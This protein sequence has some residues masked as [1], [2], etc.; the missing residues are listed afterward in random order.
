MLYS[1]SGNIKNGV[2][3][4]TLLLA[5]IILC[6]GCSFPSEEE[7]KTNGSIESTKTDSL[8]YFDIESEQNTVLAQYEIELYWDEDIIGMMQHGTV[9]TCEI[10]TTT[11]RHT[12]KA[13]SASDNDIEGTVQVTISG[14][15]TVHCV[16]HSRTKRIDIK[17]INVIEGLPQKPIMPIVTGMT[18]GEAR[19]LLIEL[20]FVNIEYTTKDNSSIWNEDNW[21]IIEQNIESGTVIDRTEKIVLTCKKI[22]EPPTTSE[23]VAELGGVVAF[24]GE[25]K[26]SNGKT[27][28]IVDCN[29]NTL[30]R[31]GQNGNEVKEYVINGSIDGTF[32]AGD[33]KYYIYKNNSSIS[34]VH[35]EY[36]GHARTNKSANLNLTS[37]DYAYSIMAQCH[38]NAQKEKENDPYSE[39]F[40]G[41]IICFGQYEQDNEVKPIEW[42]VLRSNDERTLLVSKYV[43]SLQTYTGNKDTSAECTWSSSTIRK[44]LNGDFYNEAFSGAEKN[45]ITTTEISQEGNTTKD[46]VFL[47]SSSEVTIYFGSI[48]TKAK[49]G[50][51]TSSWW[52]RSSK[53]KFYKEYID[54]LFG[55]VYDDT[56]ATV[57]KG[58]R[59]AIWV[60]TKEIDLPEE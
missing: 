8:V 37:L 46:K 50:D 21:T 51:K 54:S 19:K 31:F 12:F 15:E 10:Q 23:I 27:Y 29:T 45:A 7:K 52:L 57:V 43:L 11:G 40:T 56:F 30:Y 16:L 41:R 26:Y 39:Y 49:K 36:T 20:G 60:K 9:F 22:G 24:S 48:S 28:V 25:Y 55:K 53:D 6:T 4:I 38:D 13:K 17:S 42:I 33:R 18:Y 44:W 14:D 32:R 35:E 1:M 3:L 34:Y 47:L 59:P 5:S 2:R 58:I